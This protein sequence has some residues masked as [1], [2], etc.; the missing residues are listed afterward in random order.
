MKNQTLIKKSILKN[1]KLSTG[2]T[3]LSLSSE[4]LS[5]H[6]KKKI[7]KI[8]NLKKEK[9]KKDFPALKAGNGPALETIQHTPNLL[10]CVAKEEKSENATA[11]LDIVENLLCKISNGNF[12]GIVFF[13]SEREKMAEFMNLKDFLKPSIEAIRKEQ[14]EKENEK[15]RDSL[16]EFFDLLEVDGRDLSKSLID[17]LSEAFV[18]LSD[19]A[20]CLEWEHET[21]N[22]E[23]YLN[24]KRKEKH[25]S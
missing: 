22:L 14:K 9:R 8:N 12:W 16:L 18:D 25:E 24:I 6:I 2:V 7:N 20:R 4:K 19:G 5:P 13:N 11:G 23:I 21:E 3:K 17:F 1:K 15:K 10:L